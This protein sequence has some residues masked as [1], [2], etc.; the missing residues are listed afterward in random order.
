M[1]EEII[2]EISVSLEFPSTFYRICLRKS[3]GFESCKFAKHSDI[4]EFLFKMEIFV[5]KIIFSTQ[6]RFLCDNRS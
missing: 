6:V 2:L 3:S 5:M 4:L 1:S